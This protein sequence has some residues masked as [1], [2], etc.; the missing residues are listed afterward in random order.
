M[1]R[2][3][4]EDPNLEGRIIIKWIFQNLDGAALPWFRIGKVSGACEK[5][6]EPSD[7]LKFWKCLVSLLNSVTIWFD[8]FHPEV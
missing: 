2:D 6:N 4:L 1:E 3:H 7:F 5:G 8:V